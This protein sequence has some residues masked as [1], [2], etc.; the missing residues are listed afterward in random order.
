MTTYIICG[1]GIPKDIDNDENYHTYLN[2]VFNHIYSKSVIDEVVII[3]CGG[4]TAMESPYE[5]TE[6]AVIA[7]YLQ[8]IMKRPE[9]KHSTEKCKFYLEQ[10]SLSTLENL[11]FAKQIFDEQKLNGMIVIFCEETRRE[12]VRKVTDIIFGSE[13][14]VQSI[15]FDVSKNRYLDAKII[16]QKES[17]ALQESLWTLESKERLEQHHEFFKRKFSF[18]RERQNQGIPHVDVIEEWYVRMPQLMKELMP[19]HPLLKQMQDQYE[20]GK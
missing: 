2:I 5:E 15:D 17:I 18:F 3:P 7:Y 19:D 6:A 14:I 4:P 20:S 11:V 8:K 9:L 1:Y 10:K 13:A 16:D 12:R